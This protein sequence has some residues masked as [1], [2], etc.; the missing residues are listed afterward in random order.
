[1]SRGSAA[2]RT[3]ANA[4][5]TR[6][7]VVVA[8]M[9]D[10]GWD[11]HQE[12]G[13]A[14]GPRADIVATRGALVA[15]V[16]VKMSLGLAVIAQAA[17]WQSWAH[18]CWVAAPAARRYGSTHERTMAER[19]LRE[20]GIGLYEV[21]VAMLQWE[22]NRVRETIPPRLHRRIAYGQWDRLRA[23]LND[24]TRTYAAAG[25]AEGKFWS[26]FRDTCERARKI[27]EDTPGLTTREV[28]SALGKHHY[29]SDSAARGALAKW[30]MAGRIPGVR[31]DGRPLRWYPDVKPSRRT[32]T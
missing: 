11:V 32:R 10:L 5:S 7:A 8:H 29:G 14:G 25:N 27:V 19:I 2:E 6:A 3:T 22:E 23:Q 26:P 21:S 31:G 18:Y 17:Y 20:W 12:V 15:V 1:M 16:E 4:E 9:R 24:G 30:L 13:W 28:V